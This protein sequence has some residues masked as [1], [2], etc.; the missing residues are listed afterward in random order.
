MVKSKSSANSISTARLAS[1]QSLY[2][3]EIS[4]S[5]DDK[6]MFDFLTQRWAENCN[7]WS[8][9]TKPNKRKFSAL[10]RGVKIE[11]SSLDEII[12]GAV[13]KD[14]KFDRLDILLKSILRAGTFELL[15]EPN[16]PL[17]VVINEYVLITHAFYFENEA[18]FVNA[19]LDSIGKTLRTPTEPIQ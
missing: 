4:G 5:T 13:D 7:E 10:V 14:R 18:A 6:I 1:V 17:A 12:S 2:E 16:V 8:E 15:R 3:A 9:G 19:V 11:K